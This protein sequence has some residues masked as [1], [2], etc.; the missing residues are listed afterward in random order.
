MPR[1]WHYAY[2]RKQ[3]RHGGE[4]TKNIGEA[5]FSN[6]NFFS[7][8]FRVMSPTVDSLVD[9]LLRRA[10]ISPGAAADYG[11]LKR[12]Y[13]TQRKPYPSV[14]QFRTLNN[15]YCCIVRSPNGKQMLHAKLL[16]K[17]LRAFLEEHSG[18]QF[19]WV[20]FSIEV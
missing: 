7:Q 14:A 3:A 17:Q 15:A 19:D 1:S 6:P 20:A 5:H 12:I 8:F 18:M 10:P 11:Y 16:E 13:A 2:L 4:S 9:A